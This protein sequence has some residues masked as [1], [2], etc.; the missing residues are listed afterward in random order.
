MTDY[1]AADRS[2]EQDGLTGEHSE[3]RRSTEARLPRRT[4]LR[5]LLHEHQEA[6]ANHLKQAH[7][8]HEEITLHASPPSR[9]T[10]RTTRL[11]RRVPK[12][13]AC[14]THYLPVTHTT[15]PPTFSNANVS[16]VENEKYD[17]TTSRKYPCGTVK[18][19]VFLD[20]ATYRRYCTSFNV[21]VRDISN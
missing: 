9:I 7:T 11:A 8:S 20:E 18:F 10:S 3:L 1:L 17:Y 5:T 6:H 2:V 4:Y 14:H 15:C 21:A 12:M 19:E 13:G 16:S